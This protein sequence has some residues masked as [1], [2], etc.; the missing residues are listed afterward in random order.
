MPAVGRARARLSV[1]VARV[2]VI[3][4][5]RVAVL[6]ERLVRHEVVAGHDARAERGERGRGHAGVEHRHGVVRA[7]GAVLLPQ[8]VDVD[9]AQVPLVERARRGGAGVVCG[10][11][12]RRV[13]GL[14]IIC[15]AWI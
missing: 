13:R 14:W 2:V 9:G 5:A 6:G 12:S 10:V 7:A 11:H 15:I 4:I 8:L 3:R 1:R